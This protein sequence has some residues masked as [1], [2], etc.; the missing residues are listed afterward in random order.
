[1]TCS[2][3]SVGTSTPV[4]STLYRSI[5]FWSAEGHTQ[6][7]KNS[8][9]NPPWD[10]CMK[11]CHNFF[12]SVSLAHLLSTQVVVTRG[13]VCTGTH[14]NAGFAPP[15]SLDVLWVN[16]GIPAIVKVNNDYAGCPSPNPRVGY[17]Q[18]TGLLLP[19]S[20]AVS[21][22]VVVWLMCQQSYGDRRSS[23]NLATVTSNDPLPL[24][25]TSWKHRQA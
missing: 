16:S 20:S 17:R 19:Q 1:M 4:P 14:M 12:H 2:S 10:Y 18:K 7:A 23:Q 13:V 5:V 15:S 8:Q 21:P 22:G 3:D 11:E 25:T 24:P 9:H 6:G